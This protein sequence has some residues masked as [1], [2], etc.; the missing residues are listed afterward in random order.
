[1]SVSY[2]LTSNADRAYYGLIVFMALASSPGAKHG[3]SFTKGTSN[4]LDNVLMEMNILSLSNNYQNS[5]S[6]E[7]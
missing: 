4:F 7:V 1:M 6:N 5:E 3:F 2:R